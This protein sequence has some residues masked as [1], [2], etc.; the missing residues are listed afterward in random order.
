MV[1]LRGKKAVLIAAA[2]LL[3]AAVSYFA[4]RLLGQSDARSLYFKAESQN[5]N[6]YIQWIK[7]SYNDFQDKHRP[8]GSTAYR[9]RNEFT[10]DIRSGGKPFGMKDASRLFDLITKSKLVVDTK[11]NPIENKSVTTASLLVE[12]APFIDA[13]FFMD[14][15][16]IYFTVPVLLPG[17]YF[18]VEQK[19][20]DNLYDRFSIPI[21]P[22]EA[23]SGLDIAETIKFDEQVFDAS[24]EGL[25][26]IFS[27]VIKKENVTFGES[28]QLT[29][30]DE[31]VSGREVIVTLDCPSATTLFRRLIEFIVEDEALL[32]HTY[33]NFA[34]LSALMDEAGVFRLSEFLDEKGIVYLNEDERKI[35][36]ALNIKKDMEGVKK[37]LKSFADN[38]ELADGI[39]MT[40]FIDKSGNILK[41]DTEIHLNSVKDKGSFKLGIN[42]G[43]STV[44]TDLKNR[45]TH[46]VL[47]RKESGGGIIEF[48][49]TPVFEKTQGDDIK[50]TISAGFSVE[51]PD[52]IKAGADIVFDISGQT[53]KN[54]LKRNNS[55]KFNAR[56]FGEGEDGEVSG[57]V[58]KV[59]WKN[60]KLGTVNSTTSI[61][62]KADLPSFSIKDLSAN[63]N[64]AREDV[65]GIDPFV[66]PAIRKDEVTNL[67]NAEDSEI[68]KV[69]MQIMAS[70]GAFY[71]NNKP[72]FDA[73][74]EQ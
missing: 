70:F 10:A 37:S 33:G 35:R 3:V 13:E 16:V 36:S 74:L 39:E 52:G 59:S 26:A 30:A 47:D 65:L 42:T 17:K 48:Y 4:V 21:R 68:N 41:R 28:R 2:V 18:S 1:K 64:I 67:I 43:A 55:V 71:I 62:V 69:E 57:E 8:Y 58:A 50:G 24:V 7:S 29:I 15:G 31:A 53:D 6:N 22:K 23:L 45:F 19:E 20:I 40:L 66:L 9:R 14:D 5:I 72:I 46:I 34:D 63:I 32:S 25:G 61:S 44:Y 27:E 56:V 60:K 38:Y 49:A 54:T 11:N 51:K 73:I 12:K